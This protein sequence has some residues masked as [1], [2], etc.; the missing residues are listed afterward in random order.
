MRKQK[1]FSQKAK[2]D[3]FGMPEEKQDND[4]EGALQARIKSG[5]NSGKMNLESLDLDMVR[6]KK[7]PKRK[8]SMDRNTQP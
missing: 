7:F 3:G 2:L 8:S 1:A 6:N 4:K 5:R